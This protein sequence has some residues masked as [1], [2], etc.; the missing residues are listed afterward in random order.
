MTSI[1]TIK[2]RNE[3]IFDYLDGKMDGDELFWFE[4]EIF[5]N[6]D[7]EKKVAFEVLRRMGNERLQLAN[8]DVENNILTQVKDKSEMNQALKA[9][10][11]RW[12]FQ[13]MNF[14]QVIDSVIINI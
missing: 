8:D 7:F 4:T 12:F 6:L 3:Q 10:K 13:R 9:R 2:F 11:K 1:E 5:V 14:F